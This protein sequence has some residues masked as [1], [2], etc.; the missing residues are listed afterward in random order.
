MP[1]IPQTVPTDSQILGVMI[2]LF[3]MAV[4]FWAFFS[5]MEKYAEKKEKELEK[6]LKELDEEGEV[7]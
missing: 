1:Y 5:Y 7:Y 4:L 3:V 6:E 2:S